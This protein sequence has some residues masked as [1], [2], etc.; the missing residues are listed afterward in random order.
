MKGYSIMKRAYIST[1]LAR[2]NPITNNLMITTT[3]RI[4]YDI[5]HLFA[6]YYDYN[7]DC[8]H[9]VAKQYGQSIASAKTRKNATIIAYAFLPYD[10][11]QYHVDQWNHVEWDSMD[12]KERILDTMHDLH[13]AGITIEFP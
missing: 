1:Q 4:G 10:L 12:A 11:A 8:W 9:V 6:T 5:N 2:R 7:Y 13:Y 3:T